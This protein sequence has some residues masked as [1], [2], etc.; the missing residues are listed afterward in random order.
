MSISN[1]TLS[2]HTESDSIS[3]SC[4]FVEFD[5]ATALTSAMSNP[6]TVAGSSITV[7]ERRPHASYRGGMSNRGN[8]RPPSQ[9]RGFPNRDGRGFDGSR[10]GRGGR[11]GGMG[12][13]R[14]GVKTVPAGN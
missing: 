2:I 1:L 10:G 5:N 11:G 13:G 4:A 3:Q 14:G 8:G 7:E 9:G 6:L 12:G